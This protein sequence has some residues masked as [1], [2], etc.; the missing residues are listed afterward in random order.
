L[1][2][3]Y[4]GLLFFGFVASMPKTI[5]P[6]WIYYPFFCPSV[7]VDENGRL[8]H[9][10]YGMR[11]I[12]GTLIANGFTRD[13]VAVIH[14]EHID[15]AVDENTEVVAITSIDPLGIGPLTSTCT[16][17]FDGTGR[18]AAKL[19][20]VLESP[21]IRKHKPKVILGGPGSWQFGA[22]PEKMDD[23]GIDHVVIGEG[24]ISAPKLIK[25]I[26]DGNSEEFPKVIDGEVTFEEDI[27]EI[28]NPS[29]IGLVEATRGCARSCAFCVPSVRKVRSIPLPQI[30]KEVK[31]NVDSGENGIILHGED[32]LLY[33]SDGLNVNS[34]AVINLFREVK[35]YAGVN[36][37]Y[38]VHTSF[39][40]VV[41]SP[42]TIEEISK[43]LELNGTQNKVNYFQVG[44]ESGSS[45]LIRKHMKGKVYPFQ[46]EEWPDI[47][48]K[49]FKILNDNHFI[50]C[51]TL[52]LGLP[53]EEKEDIQESIDL[54]RSLKGHK[55]LIVPMLFTPLETTRLEYSKG[56][57]KKDFSPEHYELI[58]AC[59]EHNLNWTPLLWSHYGYSKNA[60]V[61][62]SMDIVFRIA[63][64]LILARMRYIARKH[65]AEI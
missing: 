23:L 30:M 5:L 57:Y 17:L 32:I 36:W 9:A 21:S 48:R 13:E 16:E 1:V 11:K 51:T 40:S 14:P 35:K 20:E 50:P 31:V 10:N 22:H 25:G 12:E 53:G 56:L 58:T 39:S 18:M 24:D 7:K 47:V 4:N 27:P 60:F 2:S 54:V 65:G 6:D 41:S 55:S 33:K 38:G 62:F 59:W 8:K 46:P 15:K 44:I 19:Q 49:G 29:I 37:V 45:R 42:E 52:I 43:I 26:I 64:K 61:K 3:R 28:V 63:T 34:E